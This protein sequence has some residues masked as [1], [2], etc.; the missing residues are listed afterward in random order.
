MYHSRA[1]VGSGRALNPVQG[2]LRI[3]IPDLEKHIIILLLYV[4][5]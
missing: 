5:W 4:E 1:R 2:Q 3:Q